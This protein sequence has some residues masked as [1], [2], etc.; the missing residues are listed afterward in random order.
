MVVIDETAKRGLLASV[1][2]RSVCEES[3]IACRDAT[4]QQ[5]L[6][7]Q[8]HMIRFAYLIH[9]ETASAL[10]DCCTDI[11]TIRLGDTITYSVYIPHVW[12]GDQV[13]TP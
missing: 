5:R 3:L 6:R 8:I 9:T 10:R 12:L 4:L 11:H 2:G 1:H 7:K 13:S